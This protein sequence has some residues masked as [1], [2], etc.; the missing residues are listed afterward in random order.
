MDFPQFW[1]QSVIETLFVWQRDLIRAI[2]CSGVIV[3]GGFTLHG[4]PFG[5]R[6]HHFACLGPG[7]RADDIVFRH[8]VD[9]P[10]GTTVTDPQGAL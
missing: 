3:A 9:K 6:N 2:G 4:F 10:C 5:Q 7:V 8:K 1:F